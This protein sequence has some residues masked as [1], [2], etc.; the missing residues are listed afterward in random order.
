M[1]ALGLDL[2]SKI[3]GWAIVTDKEELIDCGEI[4]LFKHKK[5]ANPLEYIKVLF[6]SISAL[7]EKYKPEY[8]FIENIYHFSMP[9][10]KSLARVRGIAEA[11]I[12]SNNIFKIIELDAS[13]I[14]KIVLGNG[15]IKSE[16][17]CT[18]MEERYKIELK[19]R[20]FDKSDGLLVALCGVKEIVNSSNPKEK[21]AKNK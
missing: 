5:K 6:D 3:S 14:R 18:I 4:E 9:T 20:G 2:S 17:A 12:V 15:S 21:K 13:H 16:E 10:T 11:A 8:V 1:N 7:M 19:T